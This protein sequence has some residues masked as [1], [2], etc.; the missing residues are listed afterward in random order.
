MELPP[1]RKGGDRVGEGRDA[2]Q[3]PESRCGGA[4]A[5]Q[6]GRS[7]RL[8][9]NAPWASKQSTV[10]FLFSIYTT[11]L[12][13]Q[14]G[15]CFLARSS[16]SS[17]RR[18]FLLPHPY[19]TTRLHDFSFSLTSSRPLTPHHDSRIPPSRPRRTIVSIR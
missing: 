16:S 15:S 13:H 6:A 17:R 10:R 5:G 12:F 19:L 7:T 14:H 4:D 2:I 11:F 9:S 3:A 8:M 18:F 1:A